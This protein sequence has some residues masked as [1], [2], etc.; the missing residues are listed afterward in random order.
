MW[1]KIKPYLFF[2][3]LSLGTGA[4]S[5]LLTRDSM[6]IYEEI[7]TPVFAPPSILFPIVWSVLYLLM[8]VSAAMIYAGREKA[9]LAARDG[10]VLFVASLVVNF[11]WSLIFFS[12]NAFLFATLWAALLFALVA[13]TVYY[14]ARI[15]KPAAVL[16]I[17]YLLW[18]GFA[19]VLTAAIFF[20]NR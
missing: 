6:T 14:Y 3:A 10:L 20:L 8:G 18:V 4:L 9:P 15:S 5:A 13:G 11:T 19:T 12:L 1:Q 17:P 2:I 7:V 16:Q